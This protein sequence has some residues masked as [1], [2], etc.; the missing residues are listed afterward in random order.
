MDHLRWSHINVIKVTHSISSYKVDN[1][2]ELTG[3]FTRQFNMS[4]HSLK[5]KHSKKITL[6][7]TLQFGECIYS[8]AKMRVYYDNFDMNVCIIE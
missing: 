8:F 2:V 1:D 6:N 7:Y 4:P 3:N 5:T